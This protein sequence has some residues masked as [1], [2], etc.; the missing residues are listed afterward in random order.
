MIF[1]N[2]RSYRGTGATSLPHE[3]SL[4]F[5][6]SRPPKPNIHTPTQVRIVKSHT[7]EEQVS[8]IQD[9]KKI[10][11]GEPFW[12]LFH[13]LAEKIKESEFSRL[14]AG[15]L[16][17]VLTICSNLPCPDCTDHATRYLNGIN[18]NTIRTKE[19]FKMM[20]YVFHNAVNARKQ[21]PE[22][23]VEKLTKYTSGN[24]I[25]IIENFLRHFLKNHQSFA[26][27]ADNMHRKKISGGVVQWFRENIGSFN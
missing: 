4:V 2:A 27:I 17:L 19:D 18:F 1:T 10:K 9:G 21:Y 16:N 23:P 14:R 3:S 22:Y 26:L 20:M 11:W 6:N 13:V 8:I 5:T 15:M 25:P 7:Y 24:M 12:F